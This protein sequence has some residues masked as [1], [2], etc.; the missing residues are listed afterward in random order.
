MR[1][2]SIRGLMK[3]PSS[4]WTWKFYKVRLTWQRSKGLKRNIVAFAAAVQVRCIGNKGQPNWDDYLN[5]FYK[6]LF[7]LFS[8]LFSWNKWY[9]L[10]KI[11]EQVM[12][13]RS[14]HRNSLTLGHITEWCLPSVKYIKWDQQLW[15]INMPCRHK[16][17]GN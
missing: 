1:D 8:E 3:E 6:I 7:L 15:L 16:T 12:F 4:V 9:I 5:S 13:K 14:G 10:I 11:K 2:R 17:A